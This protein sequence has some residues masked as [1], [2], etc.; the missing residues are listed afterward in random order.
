V[1]ARPANHR[2]NEISRLKAADFAPNFGNLRQRLM[3]KDE[4]VRTG[5]RISVFK[6]GDLPVRATEAYFT[7]S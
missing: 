4:M 6:R 2:N 3:P 1:R 7:Q 5:R